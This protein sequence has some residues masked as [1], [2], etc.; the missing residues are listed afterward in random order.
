MSMFLKVESFTRLDFPE[1]GRF[2]EDDD[3]SRFTQQ[4][5]GTTLDQAAIAVMRQPGSAQRQNPSH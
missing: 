2:Q 1:R 3:R 4:S 5:T